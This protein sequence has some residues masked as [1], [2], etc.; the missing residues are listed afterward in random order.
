[1]TR[2]HGR[3]GTG[4]PAGVTPEEAKDIGLSDLQNPEGSPIPGLTG[5]IKNL[6]VT[7]QRPAVPDD[8][9][10]EHRGWLA[11]GVKPDDHT[12]HERAMHERGGEQ[13]KTTPKLGH[14][15]PP[16]P[17]VPVVIMDGPVSKSFISASPRHITVPPN[18][19]ADP[20]RLCGRSHR[21]RIGLLNED[22]ATNIRF[23]TRPS[24]LGNGGGAL[25][26]YVTNSYSWY[27]TQDELYAVTTS[28]SLSVT[29]SI[30]EEYGQ[31]F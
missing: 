31:E 7:R 8:T 2:A 14:D 12:P 10:A 11:H 17:P 24:D 15:T 13:R 9:L 18:S 28:S 23:A 26:P 29:L 5:N 1:M 22:T 3:K 21:L 4:R 6:A 16:P 20:V 30:I 27:Q 19:G 25:L